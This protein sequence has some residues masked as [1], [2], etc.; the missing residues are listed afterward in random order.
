M[1]SKEGLVPTMSRMV[2]K[3]LYISAE[4][5]A[6]L[7]RRAGQMGISQA[8]AVRLALDAWLDERREDRSASAWEEFARVADERRARGDVERLPR[9]PTRDELH[10]R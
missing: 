7:A 1:G 10:E 6:E 8:S 9:R 3:Q 2:R 5:D 4:Q